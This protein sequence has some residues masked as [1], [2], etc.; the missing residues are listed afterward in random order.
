MASSRIVRVVPKLWSETIGEHRREVAD[1]IL[2]TTH[3]LVEK[4]G[5]RAVT[6]SLIAE[7][8]GIGRATLYKYFPDVES[9]LVAWHHK[10]VASHL[11]A[12]VH[13]QGGSP[14]DRLRHVLET[15]ALIRHEHDD[16][17]LHAMLQRHHVEHAHAQ[18]HA[19]IRDLIAACAKAGKARD[20]VPA[21]ELATFCLQALSAPTS[22]RA[23]LKRLVDV[24]MDAL[25]A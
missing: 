8:A 2:E 23:S 13:E 5:L 15:Y 6:M 12:L 1:A 9:I 17:E 16:L 7:K 21:G 22:S 3:A 18:L 10:H 11:A 24:T 25:K 14:L 19:L 4:S 20:D